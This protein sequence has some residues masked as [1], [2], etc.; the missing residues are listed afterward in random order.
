MIEFEAN[1]LR[2]MEKITN[3]CKIVINDTGM[4]DIEDC[5]LLLKELELLINLG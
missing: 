1:F 4:S 2:L 5:G 3:G